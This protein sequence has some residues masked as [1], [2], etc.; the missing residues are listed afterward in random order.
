MEY[1]SN[2]NFCIIYLFFA[3][4][5]LHKVFKL[6]YEIF[7]MNCTYKINIYQ[8]LSYIIIEV[9]LMDTIY[10]IAFAILINKRVENY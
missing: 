8:I 10:Y 9:T 2:L 1:F 5:S 4:G 7:F 3:K 6:Y